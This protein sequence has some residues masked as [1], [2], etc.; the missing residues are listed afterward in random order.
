MISRQMSPCAGGALLL[1]CGD[2]Q[3]IRICSHAQSPLDAADKAKQKLQ[4]CFGQAASLVSRLKQSQHVLQNTGSLQCGF[5]WHVCC[6]HRSQFLQESIL[7]EEY[8]CAY[9]QSQAVDECNPADAR[10]HKAGWICGC[11]LACTGQKEACWGCKLWLP[12]EPAEGRQ[13]RHY[14]AA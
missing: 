14:T 5:W 3:Q 6:C 7:R 13:S 10:L 1:T 9:G 11:A 2:G 8:C 12:A 4:R